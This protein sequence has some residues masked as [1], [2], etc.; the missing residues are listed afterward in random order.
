MRHHRQRGDETFFLT[1]TDE[2]ASKVVRVARGAGARP[3]GR[4]STRS[5]RSTGA[6]CR[7]GST[8]T[9]TSSSARRD[10]GHKRVRPGVPPADLRQ[11]R[12][13]RGHLRGPLLRRLRGV[14]D[15]SRPRRRQVPDPRHRCPSA[16]EEKNYFFRLS[17]YQERLL[18]LYDERPDF[19]LPDFRYNE[20]R[21]FIEGGLQDFSVSRAGQP[22]G[23]PLPWDEEPGRVRL[24]RRAHQLPER[25]HVR[26]AGRGPARALL[27]RRR[28]T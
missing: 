21:S 3:A 24:G 13:L 12:H 8:P 1:G 7:S 19:V 17:A 2:H 11:R 18:A 23:V 15:R 22:W 4:T 28:A 10:E 27:A 26:A 5:S 9:S 14:Q 16:I 20:A 25:A 6:S